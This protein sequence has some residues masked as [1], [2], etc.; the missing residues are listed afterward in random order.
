MPATYLHL[1]CTVYDIYKIRGVKFVV[2]HVFINIRKFVSITKQAEYRPLLHMIGLDEP[3][4]VRF[5]SDLAQSL[6]QGFCECGKILKHDISAFQ[7]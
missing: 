6:F 7:N 1:G 5:I 4:F 2:P 3:N